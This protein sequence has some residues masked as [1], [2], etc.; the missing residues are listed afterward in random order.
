MRF[1]RFQFWVTVYAVI[2]EDTLTVLWILQ[3]LLKLDNIY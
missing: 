2:P 3:H 1:K